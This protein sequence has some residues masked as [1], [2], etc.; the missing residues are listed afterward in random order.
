[1]QW[2]A[3][4][5]P[6]PFPRIPVGY[7][8]TQPQPLPSDEFFCPYCRSP[9]SSEVLLQSHVRAVHQQDNYAM[10][11]PVPFNEDHADGAFLL[12]GMP[13]ALKHS[14]VQLGHGLRLQFPTRVCVP[15]AGSGVSPEPP[16]HGLKL[17]LNILLVV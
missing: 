14:S 7:S 6:G 16:I 1:M 8:Y 15:D 5:S 17:D 10:H 12:D 2:G 13:W 4:S 11:T 9:W 3:D